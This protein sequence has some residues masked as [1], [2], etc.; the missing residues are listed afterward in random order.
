MT[1]HVKSIN[2]NINQSNMNSATSQVISSGV[3]IHKHYMND[4]KTDIAGDSTALKHVAKKSRV[5]ELLLVQPQIQ[6]TFTY[7]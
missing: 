3:S 5:D 6:G 7:Y 2:N 4:C 1:E